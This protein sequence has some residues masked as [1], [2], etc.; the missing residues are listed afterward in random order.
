METTS[1][2]RGSI[3]VDRFRQ[4]TDEAAKTDVKKGLQEFLLAI[5]R[6]AWN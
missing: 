3:T 4:I 6:K 5:Q 2:L 1:S